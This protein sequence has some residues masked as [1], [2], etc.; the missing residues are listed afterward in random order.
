VKGIVELHGGSVRARSEGLG[1]GAEFLVS[2]PQVDAGAELEPEGVAPAESVGKR[3]LVIEDNVD[4]AQSL[5]DL[6]ELAGHEVRITHDGRS[7]LA[8]AREFR[9]HVILC[10]IGLP[11]M[12]GYEVARAIRR[13]DSLG[14]IRLIALSGY[15]QPEDRQRTRDAGFEMHIAKPLDIDSLMAAVLERA[16][17]RVADGSHGK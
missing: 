5:A 3:I 4:S 2:I 9:P 7:G 16:E 8:I 11:G 10:D 14:S 13:D 6:L 15:A 1:R 12:D 17:E